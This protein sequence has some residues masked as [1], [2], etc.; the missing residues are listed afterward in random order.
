MTPPTWIIQALEKI[1]SRGV[2]LDNDLQRELVA[3]AICEAMPTKPIAEAIAGS[4]SSVF[5][6]RSIADAGGDLAHEV[7]NNAAATVY[8][9][10]I[11]DPQER[12]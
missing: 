10:L 1:A 2:G 6:T 8:F 11:T 12:T 9:R 4:A 3:Q 7:G 5:K